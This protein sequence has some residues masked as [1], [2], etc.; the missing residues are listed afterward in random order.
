[1]SRVTSIHHINI[2][3]SDWEQTRDWYEKVLGAEFLDRSPTLNKGQLQFKLGNAEIHTNEPANL[4]QVPSVHYAVEIND[5][6]EML[7]NLD[8]LGIPYSHIQRRL[9]EAG[10]KPSWNTRDYTGN[11]YT[12]VRDP[13]GNTIELLHHPLGLEDSKGSKVE[14]VHDSNSLA[15]TRRPEFDPTS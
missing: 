3:I 7:E 9:G 8:K 10:T 5:W 15:W 14:L 12:Y 2:Q 11:H 1:M 6:D 4:V 13:D